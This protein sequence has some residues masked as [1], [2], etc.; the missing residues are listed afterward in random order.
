MTPAKSIA[1]LA[2]ALALL[3]PLGMAACSGSAERAGERAGQDV[4]DDVRGVRD[5]LNDRG[6]TINTPIPER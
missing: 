2:P 3:A 4:K 5:F 1:R 6:I